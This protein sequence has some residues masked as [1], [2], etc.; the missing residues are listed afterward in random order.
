MLTLMK[1]W[2]YKKQ[3]TYLEVSTLV[4]E[5]GKAFQV[6]RPVEKRMSVIREKSIKKRG[7]VGTGREGLASGYKNLT[8]YGHVGTV[9]RV[10]NS[11]DPPKAALRSGFSCEAYRYVPLQKLA[12]TETYNAEE[13]SSMFVRTDVSDPRRAVISR[14]GPLAPRLPNGAACSFLILCWYASAFG[15]G[16]ILV[17]SRRKADPKRKRAGGE[18]HQALQDIKGYRLPNGDGQPHGW[19]WLIKQEGGYPTEFEMKEPDA[20]QPVVAGAS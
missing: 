20:L 13:Q 9:T 14:F 6:H 8:P 15:G 1:R 17:C 2:P 19:K 10:G 12:E 7:W 11:L 4:L 18:D 3:L 16:A 5:S